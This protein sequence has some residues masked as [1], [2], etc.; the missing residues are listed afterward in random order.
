MGCFS[1]GGGDIESAST[2]S[3]AQQ[4]LIDSASIFLEQNVG[5]GGQQYPGQLTPNIPDEFYSAYNQY[6]TQQS[7]NIGD[8]SQTAIQDLIAGKPAY[9]FDPQ[10]TINQWQETYAG[11]VLENYMKNIAPQ[12]KEGFNLPGVAYSTTQ[13]DG[14]ADAYG[15]FYGQYVAPTLY[16][17]LQ[18]GQQNEFQSLSQAKSLQPGA[19][20][21]P[22]QQFAQTA[23][24]VGVG[25]SLEQTQLSAQYNEWL[26]TLAEPG[27]AV[28]AAQGI[29]GIQTLENIYAT[30]PPGLGYSIAV[31]AAGG[32]AGGYG[33][34]VAT[35][36]Q[37]S[38][39]QQE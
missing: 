38:D 3:P 29:G 36:Q 5:V 1:G 31:A 28:N 25:M 21:L 26:R 2:V 20:G 9:S 17:S 35:N 23:G 24:V 11:P 33:G 8:L 6:F 13:A 22:G 37:S 32:F 15:D 12:I 27:W 18:Q 39:N 7:G 16:N 30:Q 14:V 10:Q 34:Q 19:L 4:S